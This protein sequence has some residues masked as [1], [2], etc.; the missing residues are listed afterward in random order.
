MLNK[1]NTNEIGFEERERKTPFLGYVLLVA[2]A[3]VVLLF[4]FATLDDLSNVP[5]K[6]EARSFCSS[7]YV[8]Y[9]WEYSFRDDVY[10]N[11]DYYKTYFPQQSLK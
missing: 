3:V 5:K 9:G 7:K 11:R 2:M 10:L 4:G 8:K 6:P 1:K